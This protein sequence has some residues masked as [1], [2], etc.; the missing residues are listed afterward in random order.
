MKLLLIGGPRFLGYAIIENALEKGWEVTTFNRG[1]TEPELFPD[2]EK[3]IGDRNGDLSILQGRSWD[4][5]I[6]TCGYFP[7][8]VK[9]TTSL[10]K[11]AV[12][13]YTFISSVSA[14]RDYES[15]GIDETYPVGELQDG[16]IDEINEDTYGP[17]K[18]VC[19]KIAEEQMPGRVMNVRPGLI[20]G[21]RDPSDRFTYWPNRIARGGNVLAPGHPGI[22]VQIIDVR[23]LAQWLV[24]S[25]ERRIVGTFNATG[26]E[27]P[28]TIADVFYKCKE[29]S[30]SDAK[31]IWAPEEFLLKEGVIPFT[32]MPLW[33]PE[34]MIGM[35]QVSIE[36]AVEKGLGFR[37]LRETVED[38]LKWRESR[39]LKCGLPVNRENELLEKWH[40]K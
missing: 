34:A 10:L 32:E 25:A 35:M 40:L 36:R 14:Y 26:P 27:F 2:I 24:V 37:S 21:P 30:G 39:E 38:T 20:V 22:P 15:K 31:F 33:V 19:E 18:A 11:D 8:Q 1:K 9:A 5:V 7:R 23:D 4:A 6:D 28:L 3:L 16:D 13:H 17:L 12:E 29:V